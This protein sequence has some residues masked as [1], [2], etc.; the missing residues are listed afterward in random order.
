MGKKKSLYFNTSYSR[1]L[2]LK[3][4][5]QFLKMT[6]SLNLQ[7]IPIRNNPYV[8]ILKNTKLAHLVAKKLG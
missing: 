3:W 4:S 6:L 8:L 7:V 2:F 1:K 5:A